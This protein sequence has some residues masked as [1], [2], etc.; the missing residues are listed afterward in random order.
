M[1][2]I[3]SLVDRKYKIL[4]EIGHG[5]MSIVYLAMVERANQ[6]WAIK[7][8]RKNGATK[9]D[10]VQQGL[11][12]E[13]NIL[14]KLNHSH[15]PRIIDILDYEDSFLIVMDYIEGIDLDKKLKEGP[16]K[17]EDVV[18][19]SKQLCDVFAYLHSRTPPIIYR[20]M[21]PGN[22]KLK[23][24]GNVVL[25]DFGT[26]REYKSQKAGDDTTCLGTRGYAAPEQYGG[27]GQTDARSDIYCLGATMF[28]LI[29]GRIPG[30]PPDYIIPP[31]R[32]ICPWLPR[33]GHAGSCV[34]GLEKIIMKCTQPN[35]ANRYQNCAELMYDL[36][37]IDKISDE[38]VKGL[39]RK[40]NTWIAL[41]A[42]ALAMGVISGILA[43]A[44]T[45]TVAL[46]Y[47]EL[48]TS[49]NNATL[50]SMNAQNDN[51]RKVESD[52]QNAIKVNP[53]QSTAWI[54]LAR[55]YRS[56]YAITNDELNNMTMLLN[57][58]SGKSLENN[59]AEYAQFCFEWGKDLYFFYDKNADAGVG[60]AGDPEKATTFLKNVVGDGTDEDRY[61]S[62]LTSNYTDIYA[63]Y[64]SFRISDVDQVT[65]RNEY[66]LAKCLHNIAQQW[67][68]LGQSSIYESGYSYDDYWK[69]LNDLMDKADE[70]NSGVT[71]VDISLVRCSI[72][73]NV[74]NA[75]TTKYSE[76]T[77]GATSSDEIKNLIDKVRQKNNNLRSSV[78]SDIL[79]SIQALLDNVDK[80]C[81]NALRQWQS[82]N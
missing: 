61:I 82:M 51:Y 36:E 76:F 72:Y 34:R 4:N 70:I 7:E 37:N 21:K 35:P 20:D 50:S 30:G 60:M 74:I 32:S 3:G 22:V 80:Q 11:V 39:K 43:F 68:V 52:L 1:L 79:S 29:T 6:T 28:H 16:Q 77:K 62:R 58:A 73:S 59:A 9:D 54:Y 44:A 45:R 10:I 38:Y 17:W 65:A 48:L 13:M 23:P 75:I 24:D 67:G 19:W 40:L 69:D 31:I 33:T 55:L 27:M 81:D 47:S 64:P 5:G 15:L 26:A 25:F 53:S 49:A 78:S 18:E 56:D 71:T 41:A 2:E 46:N 8:V 14:K 63:Q 57:S 12:A 66:E 42:S